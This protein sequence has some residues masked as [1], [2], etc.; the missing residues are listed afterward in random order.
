VP[1]VARPRRP[2]WPDGRATIAPLGDVRF[3]STPA[4]RCAQNGDHSPEAGGQDHVG[5]YG[6]SD[7]QTL[8][9]NPGFPSE[10]NIRRAN[11]AAKDEWVGPTLLAQQCRQTSKFVV[12][13][14]SAVQLGSGVSAQACYCAADSSGDLS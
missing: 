4:T 12:A 3:T 1:F 13:Q 6:I 14:S 11:V 2:F 8:L 9:A 5:L 10:V 7:T